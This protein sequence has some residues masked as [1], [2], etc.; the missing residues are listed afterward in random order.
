MLGVVKDQPHNPCDLTQNRFIFPH[1]GFSKQWLS[2][3]L[4]AMHLKP[5][6]PKSPERDPRVWGSRGMILSTRPENG[7]HHL[8]TSQ[9][10][11]PDQIVATQLQREL[12]PGQEPMGI[13]ITL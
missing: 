3:H 12:V 4:L 7:L 8:F 11:G 1:M 9:C 5:R 2:F 13:W 10:Q 6:L